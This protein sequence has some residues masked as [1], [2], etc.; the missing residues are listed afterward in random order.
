MFEGLI[1]MN[2]LY[3][4]TRWESDDSFKESWHDRIR[5]LTEWISENKK[6][7]DLGSGDLYAKDILVDKGCQY[8]D[9]DW[10][11]RREETF[12]CDLNKRPLPKIEKFDYTIASGVLEYVIGLEEIFEWIA[13][14]SNFLLASFFPIETKNDL[15]S[16]QKEI[17]DRISKGMTNHLC[18]HDL[19]SVVSKEF[20][21]TDTSIWRKQILLF[22]KSNR[23]IKWKSE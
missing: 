23:L 5:K 6:V 18:L 20:T 22:C 12:V 16:Y 19:V 15:I 7:L 4:K 13:L 14:H 2:D 3:G 10:K 8:F 11:K 1:S 9:L 17:Q 21:I